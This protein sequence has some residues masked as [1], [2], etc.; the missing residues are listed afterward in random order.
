MCFLDPPPT[1]VL[2]GR[3]DLAGLSMGVAPPPEP[4]EDSTGY[5]TRVASSPAGYV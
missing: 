2:A 5:T 3:R 1:P 4:L